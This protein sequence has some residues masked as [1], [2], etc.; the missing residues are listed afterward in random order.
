MCG[1]YLDV[2]LIFEP[3]TR[4]RMTGKVILSDINEQMTKLLLYL[5]C[6]HKHMLKNG[7][8][9]SIV[10]SSST[11]TACFKLQNR[12]KVISPLNY[13]FISFLNGI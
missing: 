2:T 8:P 5:V 12:F 11:N 3:E 1:L 4:T 10:L 13:G 9:L 7:A 6:K